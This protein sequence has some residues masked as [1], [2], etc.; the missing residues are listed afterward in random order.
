MHYRNDKAGRALSVLGLGCMRFP[1][2]L[3][4]IDRAR[5]GEL[6]QAAVDGG[7]NYLDTAYTYAG[8][9]EALGHI[10]VER[11]LRDHVY[12]AT[13]LP[14]G[15]VHSTDDA[16]RI[17][18]ESCRRLQTDHIDYYLIHNIADITSWNRLCALGIR[19][20]LA[21]ARADGR[22]DRVGFSF[23]GA[24][25]AFPQLLDAYDWDFCQI[26]YNY[27]NPN[28]QAGR[29]GLQLAAAR[30]IPVIVMEPLLGG[31]LATG[32]PAR[33]SRLFEE[34]VPGRSPAD[35][36]LRWLFDQPAVT[37]VLSGMSSL[38]QL[39]ENVRVADAAAPG[40]LTDAERAVFAPV[41]AAFEESYKVHCTGCNYC[42]P[43][44]AGVNIPGCF[45]AYNARYA[46]GLGTGMHQYMTGT[47]AQNPE[48]YAGVSR[49]TRCGAC[50]P[51]CPQ[52]INIPD[53]LAQVKRVMEPFW[54]KPLTALVR[55]LMS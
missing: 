49:C 22:I 53:E 42:M 17:F 10:L 2:N 16:E 24:S 26:Q 33:C 21:R 15:R 36:G 20:W 54:F 46:V 6:V 8:S 13:K 27:S 52:T 44:P 38:Q 47:A 55:K 48:T 34:C 5:A 19:D 3:G 35:W 40:M 39:T 1:R 14:H 37:V 18:S 29:S 4:S 30:N 12:L 7:I 41:V 51:K 28:F 50:V 11:R 9:E 25:S 43:C 31:K 23:H 32:L 45:A